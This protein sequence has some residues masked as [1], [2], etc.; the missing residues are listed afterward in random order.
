MDNVIDINKYKGKWFEIASVPTWF[1]KGCKNTTAEYKPIDNNTIEVKNSCTI[2]ENNKPKEKIK[3]GK[4][5]TTEE[6]NLLKVQF[7]F[8]YDLIPTPKAPYRIEYVDKNYENA[9]VSSGKYLWILSRKDKIPDN[10]YESLINIA[11]EKKLNVNE[12]I[13]TD[14]I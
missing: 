7:R 11:T 10:K 3:I 2:I 8:L 14:K 4:A 9:I 6:N 5:F 12:L 1:Q 13:K